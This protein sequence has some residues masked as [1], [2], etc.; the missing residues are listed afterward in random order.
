[1]KAIDRRATPRFRV[2]F[3][4]TLSGRGC[5]EGIGTLQDLSLSGCRIKSGVPVQRGVPLELRIHVPHL[6]WPLM[7][8]QAQVQWIRGN[9]FGLAFL[10]LKES[11][12]TRL[13]YVIAELVDEG[14]REAVPLI[15]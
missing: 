1:M 9:I 3:R 7:I 2:Q 15:A 4:T 11:E 14:E 12:E 10:R 5:L 8:D 13:A 6:D